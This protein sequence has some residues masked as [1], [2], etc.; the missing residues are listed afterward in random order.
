MIRVFGLFKTEYIHIRCHEAIQIY[1]LVEVDAE[2]QIIEKTEFSLEKGYRCVGKR[3]VKNIID[4]PMEST[5]SLD[6]VES[7]K[8]SSGQMELDEQPS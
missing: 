3:V 4:I 1:T 5:D 2:R 8:S 7:G 6:F